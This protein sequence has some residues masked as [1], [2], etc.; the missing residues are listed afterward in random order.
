VRKPLLLLPCLFFF[1]IGAKTQTTIIGMIHDE[2]GKPVVSA[3]VFLVRAA[4]T[5]TVKFSVSDKDGRY[6]FQSAAEGKYIVHIISLGY[7]TAYSTP[8]EVAEENV[9]IPP[10]I[11]QPV[12]NVLKDVSVT[13]SRSFIE[14][15]L[16]KMVINV[17]ASPTNAGSNV[18]EVLAKSP[19]I[20]VDIDENI[21]LNGKKDVLILIDGKKTYLTG[22]DLASLLKSMPA[23][24]IDQIEIMTN[25]PAKYDAEGLGGIINIK[26]KKSKQDGWN[27]NIS[28][29]GSLNIF[30]V[31]NKTYVDFNS[32][33][34]LNFNYKRGKT[35]IFGSAG[36]S[37][38]A[39]TD[40]ASYYKT[41]YTPDYVINGY[42][43]F[44]FMG[45]FSGNYTPLNLGLDYYVNKRNTVSI[46]VDHTMFKGEQPRNRITDVWDENHELLQHYNSTTHPQYSFNRTAVNLNW[47]HTFDTLGQEIS[48]DAD[49]IY[50]TGPNQDTLKAYYADNST[51][52]LS[53]SSNHYT[54][55]AA[56]Q[57]DYTK[58][59][60]GGRFDAGVKVSAVKTILDNLFYDYSNN[61][62]IKNPNFTNHSSY[63]EN[64]NAAYANVNKQIKKWSF[65][66]GLRLENMNMHANQT[67]DNYSIN[68]TNTGLF[69]S[70]FVQYDF[71]KNNSAKISVSRRI[72]RYSFYEIMPY[73]VVTDSLDI[74][75]GNPN[76]K[77]EHNTIM[78]FDY[79][80]MNKYFFTFS[81][82]ISHDAIRY[83]AAQVG[84][85]QDD[86]I[87]S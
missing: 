66:A 87:L 72:N 32:Q 43:F 4:D 6:H 15:H 63:N 86:R 56:F 34:S 59:F 64:I 13:T 53:T 67:L 39:G 57:S 22:K 29:N 71:N 76:L 35:N 1:F 46:S 52:L 45:H 84:E 83:V 33:N 77:P 31:N 19:M 50:N 65:Q 28:T 82:T 26:T 21:S 9:T 54:N 25:P 69:P 5:S 3:T 38:F 74:W 24:N 61:E 40:S 44:N 20:I 48:F 11:L 75:H 49:Y 23:A 30:S 41:Y 2:Q 47:K 73:T 37:H 14:M 85:E 81:Y 60:K 51:S 62:W 58:P 17:E 42:T 12:K 7:D 79:S 18:L 10:I 8:F 78:E 70:I 16:D 68:R 36:F 27:G 80:F 55:I